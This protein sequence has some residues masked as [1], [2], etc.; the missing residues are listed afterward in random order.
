MPTD[1]AALPLRMTDRKRLVF[2]LVKLGAPDPGQRAR[3]RR[4]DRREISAPDNAQYS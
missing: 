1:T 3:V 2:H 4:V